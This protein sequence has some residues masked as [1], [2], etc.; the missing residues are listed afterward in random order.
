MKICIIGAGIAGLS[1]AYNL[2][3]IGHEVSIYESS[4]FAGGQASTIKIDDFDQL[5]NKFIPSLI[6]PEAAGFDNIV[7]HP[8]SINPFQIN[9]KNLLLLSLLNPISYFR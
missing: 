6:L 7:I 5:S 1:A 2:S 8:F 3:K 9:N 4:P